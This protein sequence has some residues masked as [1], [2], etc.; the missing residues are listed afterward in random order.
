MYVH[1]LVQGLNAVL[2]LTMA[3]C[4]CLTDR[5]DA[6]NWL[7][8]TGLL[9]ASWVLLAGLL[10]NAGDFPRASMRTV[11]SKLVVFA[12]LAAMVYMAFALL[13]AAV[14]EFSKR[15]RNL[16]D[17]NL[18]P[19]PKKRQA[20]LVQT[21]SASHL[22]D[23]EGY[24]H[25]AH[26][27]RTAPASHQTPVVSLSGGLGGSESS[28]ARRIGSHPSMRP[29]GSDGQLRAGHHVPRLSPAVEVDS[30][31]GSAHF[32]RTIV[33]Q[34]ELSGIGSAELDAIIANETV[35]GEVTPAESP[36]H[37]AKTSPAHAREPGTSRQVSREGS[38]DGGSQET[39]QQDVP[40][41]S[42]DLS[43]ELSRE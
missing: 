15:L 7:E 43:R 3:V 14:S 5:S 9:I 18:P 39:G 34:S 6:L 12:I 24:N 30:L 13:W 10:F 8:F 17:V 11:V 42:R 23:N 2:R 20:S 28:L 19:G 16:D 21:Y 36:S 41:V 32:A 31:N 27:H 29:L 4:M 22:H 38:G 26:G 35:P 40:N 25:G 37:A 1:A 33:G